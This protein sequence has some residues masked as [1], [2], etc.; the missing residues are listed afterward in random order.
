MG[1]GCGVSVGSRVSVG[2]GKSC[3]VSVGIV[4]SVGGGGGTGVSV[5]SGS[6][7][8][9]WTVAVSAIGVPGLVADEGQ[10]TKT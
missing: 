10:Q 9:G 8:K 2:E 6:T 7:A 5:G 4:V 3:G 1:G